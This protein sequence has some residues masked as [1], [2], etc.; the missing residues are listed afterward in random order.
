MEILGNK[1]DNPLLAQA[2]SLEKLTLA[3]LAVLPP[4]C[5]GHYHV[6]GF[7]DRTVIIVCDSPVW[8][9]RLRQLGPLVVSCLQQ[10]GKKYEALQHV[11][12]SSRPASSGQPAMQQRHRNTKNTPRKMSAQS[13]KLLGQTAVSITDERLR[14]ALEKLAARAADS[15]S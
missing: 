13:G 2:R 10:Q 3:L 6:A 5:S 4:E 15:E 14:R 1:L 7:R 8:A 12:V 11:Q 9:T